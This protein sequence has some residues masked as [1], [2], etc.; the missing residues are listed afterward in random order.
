MAIK[1][2]GLTI[3]L[4]AW[5]T[6]NNVPKTEDASNISLYIIKDGGSA[7]SAT[8]SITEPT[9]ANMPGIYE[10]EL[11]SS[12]M[13]ANFI[14]VGGKSS[15]SNVV[16]YPVFIQTEQGEL[17]V[18]ETDILST[19]AN[20]DTINTNLISVSADIDNINTNLLLTS[21]DIQSLNDISTSDVDNTINNNSTIIS[22]DQATSGTNTL[23][24]ALNDISTSDV[25]N[26]INNNSTIISID[27]ATSGTNTLINALNDISTSD[28]DTIITN[29]TKVALIDTHILSTSADIQSLN[30]ISTSDVLTQVNSALDTAIPELSQEVPTATPTIRTGI[31]FPYMDLRNKRTA[32]DSEYGIYNDA[33]T[34]IA[35]AVLSD[36]GTTFTKAE[37]TTGA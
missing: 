13:D 23:I 1:G 35:K 33:G 17:S 7:T 18:L 36:N 16:I 3:N 8:N 12:E 2:N 6:G 30:D 14:T 34:K 5:D 11:T 29:N 4:Y 25:D 20:V 21:A 9:S 31:M 26:T 32:T 27:Q 22:I 28:V 37:F 15:T 19:S 10:L 24:N